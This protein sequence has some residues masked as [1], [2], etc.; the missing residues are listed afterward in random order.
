MIIIIRPAAKTKRYVCAMPVCP[1]LITFEKYV[2][3]PWRPGLIPSIM[4][5]SKYLQMMR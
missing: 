2:I 1:A 4:V 5:L 3:D